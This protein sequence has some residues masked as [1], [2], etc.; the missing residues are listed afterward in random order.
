MCK[1]YEDLLPQKK[2]FPSGDALGK[3]NFSWGNKL[4]YFS[5]HQATNV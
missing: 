1:E 4:L 3:Y 2:K 5:H